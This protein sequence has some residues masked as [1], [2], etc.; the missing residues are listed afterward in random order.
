MKT[1]TKL[2]LIAAA[3]SL[4]ACGGGGGGVQ[5]P[6]PINTQ[7]P[8]TPNPNPA[9]SI[10]TPVGA[11]DGK[12]T[13]GPWCADKPSAQTLRATQETSLLSVATPS[14][15]TLSGLN[16]GAALGAQSVQG[17]EIAALLPTDRPYEQSAAALQASGVK[18]NDTFGFWVT[19]DASQAQAIRAA[20]DAGLVQYA[21]KLPTLKSAALPAANDLKQANTM[22]YLPIMNTEAAWKSL[23][24]GCDHPIVAVIDTGIYGS[25]TES[26]YNLT[27]KASWFDGFRGIQGSAEPTATDLGPHDHEHGAA[28]AGVIATATNNGKAGAGTTYNLVKVLPINVMNT[29]G[30]VAGTSVTRAL[31][32][33]GGSTTIGDKTYVNP[34]PAN[35]INLSFG[36]GATLAPSKFYQA[37]FEA[38]AK[39]GIVIVAAA[40]NENAHGTTDTAGLNYSIGAGGIGFDGQRWVTNETTG[41][42]YGPGV[43]VVAPAMA[44]PTIVDGKEMWWSGTSM[45][46]PWVA[47]QIALWMYANQ[48]YRA[49]SSKTQGLTGDALYNKLLTCFAAVGNGGGTKN[50]YVGYGILDTARLVSPTEAACR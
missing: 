14:M 40:G 20:Y 10:Y 23:D 37:T 41:S 19:A 35:V 3:L 38:L 30:G 27:P 44:V 39:R 13:A 21:E 49:D 34:Y 6:A 36:S 48:Q 31:E 4:A 15:K 8:V 9:T 26:E 12:R 16:L 46:A 47:G 18:L 1:L 22:K 25:I 17:S 11:W 50:E 24:L 32:Y 33:A 29:I 42:N 43:D 5:P 7:E 28:V 2:T 45:A